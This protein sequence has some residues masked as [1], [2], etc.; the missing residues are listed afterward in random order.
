MAYIVIQIDLISLNFVLS[1]VKHFEMVVWKT[2][3]NEAIG[4][5]I[6]LAVRNYKWKIKTSLFLLCSPGNKWQVHIFVRLLFL[7]RKRKDIIGFLNTCH[8]IYSDKQ[9]Y[10]VVAIIIWWNTLKLVQGG[11]FSN[12]IHTVHLAVNKIWMCSIEWSLFYW[13]K[14]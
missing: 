12:I 13:K 3:Y 5:S 14:K 11:P 2:L 4:W 9:M 7:E 6:W 8:I 10:F 1:L